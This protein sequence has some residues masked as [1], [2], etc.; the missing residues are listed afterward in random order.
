MLSCVIAT[1]P[2]TIESSLQ[3]MRT[4]S[5]RKPVVE[6]DY[7]NNMVWKDG[8]IDVWKVSIPPLSQN[9]V[10]VLGGRQRSGSSRFLLNLRQST[11]GSGMLACLLLDSKR[12]GTKWPSVDATETVTLAHKQIALV[13][14]AVPAFSSTIANKARSAFDVLKT[15]IH[16]ICSVHD[17]D[18]HNLV[19]HNENEA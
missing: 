7:Y 4:E 19:E 6:L 17:V 9:Q 11:S 14:E 18:F 1:F 3:I 13:E 10:L 5:V 15:A 2:G 12:H 8:L 16:P